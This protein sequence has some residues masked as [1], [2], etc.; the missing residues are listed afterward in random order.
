MRRCK[1]SKIKRKVAVDPV[2]G[3]SE[4]KKKPSVFERLGPG[5]AARRPYGN[6]DDSDSE[7][8]ISCFSSKFL[9]VK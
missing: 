4:D 1:M 7:V 8:Q 5:G 6:Y 3:P 9:P 2:A